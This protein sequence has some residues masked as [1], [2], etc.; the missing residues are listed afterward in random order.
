M[1]KRIG[2]VLLFGLLVSCGGSSGTDAPEKCDALVDRVCARAISCANDG[3][4]QA[5]CVAEAKTSLPCAEA[6]AVSDGYDSCMSEVQTSPCSVL[7]AN[8]TL[9]LPAT[10]EGSILFK[11]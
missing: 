9:N 6:D 10:C 3:T 4:T 11:P 2:G 1:M 8:D 7:L 5:E